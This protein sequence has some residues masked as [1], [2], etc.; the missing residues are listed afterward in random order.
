MLSEGG[1]QLLFDL[2]RMGKCAPALHTGG[3]LVIFSLTESNR[4]ANAI[5]ERHGGTECLLPSP[6][7]HDTRRGFSSPVR[8]F[9]W[10]SFPR[11]SQ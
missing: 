5:T 10:Q 4:E 7:E 9:T 6:S 2:D 1:H 3:T 11:F 8:E